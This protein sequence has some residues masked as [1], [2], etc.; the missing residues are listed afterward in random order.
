MPSQNLIYVAFRGSTSAKDWLG[1]FQVGIAT[2]A[3]C[4]G[5]EVHSG[6]YDAEQSVI[7]FVIEKTKAVQQVHPTATV[8]ITG[9]SLGQ[10]IF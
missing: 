2:Y 9:H 8:V 3:H 5:C 4:D 10:E 7:E 6:F 1:N